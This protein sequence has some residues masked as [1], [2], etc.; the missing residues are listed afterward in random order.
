MQKKSIACPS[1]PAPTARCRCPP[2]QLR[3]AAWVQERRFRQHMEELRAMLEH[4]YKVGG[5]VCGWTVGGV[6]NRR[7][8]GWAEAG[9]GRA[10]AWCMHSFFEICGFCSIGFF[11]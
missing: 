11:C 1:G 6:A 10:G 2:P 3:H 4:Y 8:G 9:V 5:W 7:V